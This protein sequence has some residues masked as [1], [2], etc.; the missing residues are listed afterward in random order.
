MLMFGEIT[1][2]S[3]QP[4]LLVSELVQIVLCTTSDLCQMIV[5][6]PWRTYHKLPILLLA[7]AACTMLYLIYEWETNTTYR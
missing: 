5:D 7:P 4:N 1:R 3:H 2:V 6:R